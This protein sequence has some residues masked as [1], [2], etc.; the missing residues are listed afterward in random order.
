MGPS[1][2]GLLP[3]TDVP[4][5]EHSSRV[6]LWDRKD[7][8]FKTISLALPLLLLRP[9]M[10]IITAPIYRALTVHV[11]LCAKLLHLWP[12]RPNL[13]SWVWQGRPLVSQPRHKVLVFSV[14]CAP[15]S[16]AILHSTPHITWFLLAAVAYTISS[17]WNA[18]S[19]S[20]YHHAGHRS[21]P[22]SYANPPLQI[23]LGE[24]LS[25]ECL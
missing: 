25:S 6:Y 17:I 14:L 24:D 4:I 3:N 15:S 10:I 16:A 7:N 11:V 1:E 13:N 21:R 19:N 5:G 2:N 8:R 23:F 12:H 18:F 22:S 20:V 9:W